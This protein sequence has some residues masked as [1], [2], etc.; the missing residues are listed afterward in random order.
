MIYI[1]SEGEWL[2][3]KVVQG[4][5]ASPIESLVEV[6]IADI[7]RHELLPIPSSQR[8]ACLV[9]VS[10]SFDVFELSPVLRP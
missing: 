2:A 10:T 4:F 7:V 1:K 6:S 5:F 3:N 9:L 8:R